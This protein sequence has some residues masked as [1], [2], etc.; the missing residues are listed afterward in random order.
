MSAPL[1]PKTQR[2]I[3]TPSVTEQVEVWASSIFEDYG[4]D[5]PRSCKDARQKTPTPIED[6]AKLIYLQNVG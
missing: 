3:P 2:I 5:T 4:V 1:G 6:M